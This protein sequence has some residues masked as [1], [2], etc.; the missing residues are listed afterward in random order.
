MVLSQI[1]ITKVTHAACGILLSLSP[2]NELLD[3]AL[4]TLLS[5]YQGEACCDNVHAAIID[6]FSGDDHLGDLL[7]M[8]SANCTSQGDIIDW[9][10]AEIMSKLV[11]FL[12]TVV[13]KAGEEHGSALT[14]LL[15]SSE[16]VQTVLDEFSTQSNENLEHRAE[17]RPCC[18]KSQLLPM[19]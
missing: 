11:S 15:A 1:Q 16:V 5:L 3:R 19:M 8:C 4:R 12:C 17:V 13:Q 9:Q 18:M 7:R 10:N 14:A 6:R 2:R